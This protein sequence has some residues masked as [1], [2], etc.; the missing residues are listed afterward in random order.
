MAGSRK[1]R[2]KAS[3]GRQLAVAFAAVAVTAGLILLLRS[4]SLSSMGIGGDAD[5][6]PPCV[7]LNDSLTN[8]CS[9]FPQEEKISREMDKFLRFWGIKGVSLA[10]MRN[11]SLVF[12]KGYGWADKELGIR[13]EAYHKLRIASVSK[14]ITATGIMKLCEEGR[15][16][17]DTLVFGENGVLCDS[18]YLNARDKR[19][20]DITV[21]HLLRH[22][23]G[24]SLSRGDPMFTTSDIMRWERMNEPPDQERLVEYLLSRRLGF[25]PGS[26]QKYSN[27]GYMFLSL[28]IEKVTGMPY[29]EYMREYIMKPAGCYDMHL[30]HNYYEER[31]PGES[32]YYMH[33]DA[34]PVE[35]FH[36]D[37]RM[38]DK[39]YG[40]SDFERL[41]GAGG[42]I[43][44]AP[45]LARFVASID[46]RPEVPDILSSES[47]A[48]MTQYI[49]QHTFPLGWADIK[50]NGEWHRSG[51]LSGTSVLVK[52]LPDGDCWILITNSSTWKGPLFSKDINRLFAKLDR[53]VTEW[54]RRDLFGYSPYLEHRGE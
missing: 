54:P 9:D 31:F 14:L 30:G 36:L 25:T 18:L 39:C 27:V 22:Q 2:R 53:L 15:L 50:P 12:A 42:W 24:F 33:R 6:I 44:S 41:M 46:G 43:T 26:R 5:D 3:L 13:M 38:V 49:D 40:G 19:M 32:R 21:E 23:G 7:C 28:V 17:L 16:S 34:R 47:I 48:R 52:Y 8:A 29:E 10:M 37:G 35:D 11:D 4:V 45:E 20:Y 1:S 51:T